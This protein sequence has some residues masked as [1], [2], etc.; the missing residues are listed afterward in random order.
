MKTTGFIRS[1]ADLAREMEASKTIYL[2]L[3][4]D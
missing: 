3:W 4:W 2:Y 1:N